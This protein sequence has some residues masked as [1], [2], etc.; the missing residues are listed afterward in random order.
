MWRIKFAEL[1]K[2]LL[3]FDKKKQQS[4]IFA[5]CRRSEPKK[6]FWC[7]ILGENNGKYASYKHCYEHNLFK[8]FGHGV[9]GKELKTIP[10]TNI[11]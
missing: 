2:S 3:K 6:V 5:D 10:F 9:H 7:R 8:F 1:H 11:K 4:A